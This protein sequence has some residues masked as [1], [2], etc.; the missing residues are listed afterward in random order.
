MEVEAVESNPIPFEYRV[1]R[2]VLPASSH[3]GN[4]NMAAGIK[5]PSGFDLPVFCRGPVALYHQRLVR[6]KCKLHMPYFPPDWAMSGQI[7]TCP[8]NKLCCLVPIKLP[9]ESLQLLLPERHSW[10]GQ[11][12]LTRFPFFRCPQIRQLIEVLLMCP[13]S[14]GS[15]LSW[16]DVTEDFFYLVYKWSDATIKSPWRPLPTLWGLFV[17]SQVF[18]RTL[19]LASDPL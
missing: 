15:G 11:Q 10:G 5:D 4:W 17:I 6:G 13:D 12:I 18:W 19:R 3:P 8:E 16:T 9:W 14:K 2:L 7:M 1:V